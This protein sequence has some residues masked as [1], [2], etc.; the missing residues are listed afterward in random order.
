MLRTSAGET[1]RDGEGAF[2]GTRQIRTFAFS[3]RLE[4]LTQ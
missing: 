3:K 2:T 1:F 4:R